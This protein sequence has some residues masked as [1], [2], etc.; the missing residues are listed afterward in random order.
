MD[1]QTTGKSLSDHIGIRDNSLRE[2]QKGLAETQSGLKCLV[3][4]E[5][6]KVADVHEETSKVTDLELRFREI[7]NNQ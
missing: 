7:E 5:E 4:S 2:T 1:P 3:E 6:Q